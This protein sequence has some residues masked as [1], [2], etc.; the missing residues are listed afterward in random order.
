MDRAGDVGSVES[1]GGAPQV[2]TGFSLTGF[3]L[4][5]LL[6]PSAT[7]PQSP[8]ISSLRRTRLC[9]DLRPVGSRPIEPWSAHPEETLIENAWP[10]GRHGRSRG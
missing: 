1:R 3:P 9:A 10:V 2:S 7:P 4:I 6:P 5:D 8:N